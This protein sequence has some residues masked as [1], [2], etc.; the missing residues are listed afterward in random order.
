MMRDD[1][2]L[3]GLQFAPATRIRASQFDEVGWSVML[4]APN[5]RNYLVLCCIDLEKCTWPDHGIHREVGQPEMSMDNATC[6]IF[7]IIELGSVGYKA[8][9]LVGAGN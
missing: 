7:A 2:Q 9:L 8:R 4:V 3:I 5:V 6:V 1:Q